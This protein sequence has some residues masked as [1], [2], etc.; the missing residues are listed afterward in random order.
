MLRP[1]RRAPTIA[2]STMA[3]KRAMREL[4]V[5][6]GVL[7]DGSGRW[8]LAERPA[9]KAEAGTWEFPGGKCEPG[10]SPVAALAR[11]LHEELGLTVRAA[12]HRGTVLHQ[13]PTRRL[14]LEV[15]EATDWYGEPQGRE[16]QRLA[17]VPTAELLARPM[18]LPDRPIVRAL[19]LPSGYAI[20]PTLAAQP[21]P[22]AADRWRQWCAAVDA[23]LASGVRLISLRDR[24]SPVLSAQAAFLQECAAPVGA[25]ALLHGSPAEAERLGFDGVHLSHAE[26]MATTGL[27]ATLWRAASCHDAV[28]LRRAVELGCDLVT[29]SPVQPTASHPGAAVLGWDGFSALLD[30][31]GLLPDQPFGFRPR[32]YALGG[33]GPADL[34]QARSHGAHGIAAIRGWSL[35]AAL[36][37]PQN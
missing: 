15:L 10:E 11:E 35:D 2:G 16:G 21:G 23:S 26:L 30:A 4:Q 27:P 8:L 12:E 22:T 3:G 7:R 13:T 9:G 34:A 20:T 32:V 14:R 25:I 31:A 5:V 33:L 18:P 24:G 19:A 28:S 6:A 17:W 29:L 36:A 1:V 37:T